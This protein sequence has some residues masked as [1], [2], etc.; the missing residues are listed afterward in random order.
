MLYTKLTRDNHPEV[1]LT[2][3]VMDAIP[4]MI[5]GEVRPAVVVCPGGGYRFLSPR[6]AENMAIWFRQDGEYSAV[7]NLACASSF[8]TVQESTEYLAG[9][10]AGLKGAERIDF[11]GH[12][13]GSILL[14][15]GFGG[16][17]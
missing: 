9:I 1:C 14:R 8:M 5:G 17:C 16:D 15:N 13:L 12:S 10:L 11:V 6:E 7:L 2:T 4:G 3:Y